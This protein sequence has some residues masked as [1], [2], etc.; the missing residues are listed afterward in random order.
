MNDTLAN[1][2]ANLPN[3]STVASISGGNETVGQAANAAGNWGLD[4]LLNAQWGD[5]VAG[6]LNATFNTG[7]FSG[8]TIALLL[9]A[10]SILL[11]YWKW[12]SVVQFISTAGQVI[13]ILLL[14]FLGLKAFHVL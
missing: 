8:S 10:I 4:K 12:N 9:P 5:G 3:G 6:W 14:V 13:L 7:I 11:I 2:T 1:L